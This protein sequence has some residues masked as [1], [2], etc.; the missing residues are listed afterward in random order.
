MVLLAKH[1]VEFIVMNAQL[2]VTVY[3]LVTTEQYF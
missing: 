3:T 2:I 1:A